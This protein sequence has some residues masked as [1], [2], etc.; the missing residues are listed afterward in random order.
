MS[1]SKK[2]IFFFLTAKHEVSE[3]IVAT[4]VGTN[5]VCFEICA[6]IFFAESLL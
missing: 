4:S 2:R 1:W 3:A 5:R 6:L